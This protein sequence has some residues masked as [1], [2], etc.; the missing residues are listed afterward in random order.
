MSARICLYCGINLFA[1]EHR[2]EVDSDGD[3]RDPFCRDRLRNELRGAKAILAE[4]LV[5][6]RER[7]R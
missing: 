3:H 4:A 2:D 1:P 5:M 6:L 7:G